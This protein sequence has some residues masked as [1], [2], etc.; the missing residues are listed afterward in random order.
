TTYGSLALTGI[1]DE[2]S[3]KCV[4]PLDGVAF[5]DFPD[6]LR[7]PWGINGYL[8]PG[9]LSESSL[10][11]IHDAIAALKGDV[12]GII[13]EPIQG[14]SGAIIPP[15]GYMT[16]LQALCRR[17]GLI[18]IAEEIQ[19]GMGRTGKWWAIENFDVEPDILVTG[20]ALGG[21]MPISAVV[22]RKEIMESVPSPFFGFTHMGHAV[23]SAAALAAIH[24][25]EDEQLFHKALET[26]DYIAERFS[27]MARQYE[28]LG[29]IRNKGLL[30]GVEVTGDGMEIPDR[31]GAL[32]ICW[33]AWEKG[34][35]II[36]FGKLGNV[37]R[38]APPLN[39]PMELVDRA[40][41]IIDESIKDFLD[42]KI[43]DEV[44]KYLQGW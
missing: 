18:L 33:R 7:N 30:F 37:L 40:M 25:T 4:C 13:V 38:I 5:A 16:G 32:K 2:D 17:Y 11:Q 9:K 42:G 6:P 15:E 26:G 10:S 31:D 24:I 35:V 8:E 1:I 23:N 3:K 12:A 41:E 14:D 39:I 27:A 34:L 21:G 22:G 29:D 28:I 36:T 43:P 19:S 44:V 20:K